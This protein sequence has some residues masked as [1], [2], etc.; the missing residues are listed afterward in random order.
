MFVLY[1]IQVIEVADNPFVTMA[2]NMFRELLTLKLNPK[3]FVVKQRSGLAA[4][5]PTQPLPKDIPK[6]MKKALKET[7]VRELS[8]HL[9]IAIEERIEEEADELVSLIQNELSKLDGH[10]FFTENDP[11]A[12]K[13]KIGLYLPYVLL[14]YCNHAVAKY[15][16]FPTVEF[17]T[18]S[19]F[20][21]IR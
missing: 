18:G 14:N 11:I 6:T 19:A 17:F 16:A 3:S 20:S 7:A 4:A 5:P 8:L 2:H 9:P 15:R 1:L 12:R 10:D 13:T 21:I